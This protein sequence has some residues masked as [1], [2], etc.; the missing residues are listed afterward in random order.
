MCKIKY[1]KKTPN[2]THRF[3]KQK[4]LKML[5]SLLT[6]KEEKVSVQRSFYYVKANR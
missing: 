1:L 3:G 5:C 4:L 6:K 2:L